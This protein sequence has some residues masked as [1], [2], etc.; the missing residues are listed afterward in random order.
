[1]KI[2]FDQIKADDSINGKATRAA[3]EATQTEIVNWLESAAGLAEEGL[4]PTTTLAL[5]PA[6]A[7][8]ADWP[9]A[10][11]ACA[12]LMKEGC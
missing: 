7:P 6:V 5:N 9:V 11:R 12:Q 2:N 10:F 4:T 3:I 1:M 8:K